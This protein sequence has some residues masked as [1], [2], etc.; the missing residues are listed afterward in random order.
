VSRLVE[1]NERLYAAFSS[2]DIQK[3]VGETTHFYDAFLDGCGNDLIRDAIRSVN[4]RIVYLRV[5]SMSQ[6]GRWPGSRDEMQRIVDAITR[7]SPD[8]AEEACKDH[9]RRAWVAAL[10]VL[11]R[12][13]DEFGTD[14]P[15]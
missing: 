8:D 10:E 11:R 3:I 14:S 5:T 4:A 7:R 6:P 13:K 1:A 12:R 2:G 15:R 9:V